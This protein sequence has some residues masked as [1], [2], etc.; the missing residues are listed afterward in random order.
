MKKG[1]SPIV[2]VVLL[3]AISVI[4]AVGLYFWVT[5]FTTAPATGTTPYVIQA[6]CLGASSG[7]NGTL[8]INNI[9]T[10]SIPA[11]QLNFQIGSKSGTITHVAL[12][13]SSTLNISAANITVDLT[14]GKN[15]TVWATGGSA[16][17]FY[18]KEA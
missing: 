13:P 7:Y 10:K 11:G 1:I 8:F 9:G 5:A 14:A 16:T 4:A 12:A 6:N 2:A 15:G 3:I 18:C 17:S